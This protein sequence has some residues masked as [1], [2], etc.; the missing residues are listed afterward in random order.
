[1]TSIVLHSPMSVMLFFSDH[2]L[3][4][5]IKYLQSKNKEFSVILLM[6]GAS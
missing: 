5:M 3:G 4:T 2:E 6:E 1:M